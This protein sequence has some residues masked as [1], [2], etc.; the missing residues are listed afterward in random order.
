MA[1]EPELVRKTEHTEVLEAVVPGW[2]TLPDVAE[3]QGVAIPVARQQLNDREILAVRRTE[4]SVLCI[5]EPFVTA[6]GP[7]PELRGTFTVLADGGM[8]DLELMIWLFTPDETLKGGSPMGA[9]L[10]GHKTEVRRRAMELA[11]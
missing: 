6:D 4:R 10:A 9:L 1:G 11:Y 8:S 3:R 7:R 2:L 5:P